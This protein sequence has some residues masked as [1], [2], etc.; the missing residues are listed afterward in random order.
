MVAQRPLKALLADITALAVEYYELTGKPL[1]VTGE[2]AECVAS[3]TLKLELAPAR[4]AGFDAIRH[5][6]GG[7]QKIQIKGRWKKAGEKWGRVSRIDTSKEFDAVM[8]VL[9]K[10]KYELAEIWEAPREKVIERLSAP[11]SRARN[12][13]G[14]M[15]VSQFKSIAKKV[16][17]T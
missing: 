2:V 10:G 9:M 13:R 15:G 3:A 8:L 17:P 16:W 14:A 4:S 12:E 7:Q 1:G 5:V 11:G 6:G